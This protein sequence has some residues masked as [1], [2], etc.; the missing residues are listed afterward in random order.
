MVETIFDTLNAKAA[1]SAID[2]FYIETNKPRLPLIISGTITDL[3]GRTLSGQVIEAFYISVAH[4]KPFCIGLNCALGLY[5]DKI[6]LL[7]LNPYIPLILSYI[8]RNLK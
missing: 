8:A 4:A 7:L 2:E 3:S 6:L 1:L 5:K